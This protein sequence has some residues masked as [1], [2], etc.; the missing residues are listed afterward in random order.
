MSN[1]SRSLLVSMIATVM[2]AWFVSGMRFP[3]AP[4]HRCSPTAHYLYADHP[5]GYCGKLGQSRTERDFHIFQVW[6]KGQ[7]FIW[8]CGMLAL[9]LLMSKR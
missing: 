9:A 8:P 4:I 1:E 3:D 5:N 7:N 6:E 2:G